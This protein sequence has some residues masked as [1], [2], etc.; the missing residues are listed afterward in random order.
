[1]AAF[2][3]A[4]A[5][6]QARTGMIPPEWRLFPILRKAII[7]NIITNSLVGIFGF[8][9]A[10]YLFFTGSAYVPKFLPDNWFNGTSGATISLIES[11]LFV[12][13][14]IGFLVLAVR[15]VGPLRDS[16]AYFFLITPDGF[17]EVK[18]EKVMGVALD[19]VTDLRLKSGY[20]GLELV[21]LRRSGRA[22]AFAIDKNYGPPREMYAAVR[23]AITAARTAQR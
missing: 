12:A 7:T 3:P 20:L 17:A 22:L 13:V 8:A 11:L 19:N 14:G 4:G 16:Q 2:D 5:A 1:M 6:S 21:A 23:A 10:A 9:M 15:W 18:G